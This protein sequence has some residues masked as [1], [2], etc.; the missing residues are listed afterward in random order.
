MSGTGRTT[1]KPAA[2]APP[3]PEASFYTN[4]YE[5][6][7]AAVDRGRAG[8]Q[9]VETAAAAVV[10]LYTGALAA[11]FSATKTPLPVRGLMPAVYL[12]LA[13]AFA[14]F[15]LAYPSTGVQRTTL[16]P[17]SGKDDPSAWFTSF[18]SWMR[19]IVL[20]RRGALRAALFALLLGVMFLPAPFVKVETSTP[21]TPKVAEWPTLPSSDIQLQKILYSAQ[22]AE[23]AKLR[24]KAAPQPKGEFTLREWWLWL[25]FAVGLVIVLG[26]TITRGQLPEV[27]HTD[28][29]IPIGPFARAP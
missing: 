28:G 15:Y 25:A 29:T 9:F 6:A 3:T 2:D 19:D 11:A 23:V 10:T 20:R 16:P 21:T 22:V 14:A 5:V 24:E 13:I 27:T 1:A 18:S 4:A 17:N 7:K 8:A 12:G 26:S